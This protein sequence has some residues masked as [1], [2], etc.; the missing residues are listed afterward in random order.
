MKLSYKTT[1]FKGL[2][3][4]SPDIASTKH[5]KLI[6]QASK[7]RTWTSIGAR[8]NR[9]KPKDYFTFGL[10]LC[11][12]CNWLYIS[13]RIAYQYSSFLFRQQTVIKRM[14]SSIRKSSLID[15][16]CFWR[17]WKCLKHPKPPK[18]IWFYC[19][20]GY[21]YGRLEP[22]VFLRIHSTHRISFDLLS[23]HTYIF[24][25]Q[26]Y[27]SMFAWRLSFLRS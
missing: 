13:L 26:G 15:P 25:L 6:L 2:S 3:L 11:F 12:S 17:L 9:E 18:Q 8:C 19:R 5:W 1:D 24:Q 14:S 10:N 22:N 27:A 20:S 23:F 4:H 7:I 21:K 16:Y